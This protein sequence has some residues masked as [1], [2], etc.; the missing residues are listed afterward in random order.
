MNLFKIVLS[1]QILW[2]LIFFLSLMEKSET[3]KHE[4]I[5][6]KFERLMVEHCT[7]FGIKFE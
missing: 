6:L 2:D 1:D 5:E 7:M 3:S 4:G